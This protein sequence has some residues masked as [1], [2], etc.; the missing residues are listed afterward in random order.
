M[1]YARRFPGFLS[2]DGRFFKDIK[3][4]PKYTVRLSVNGYNLTSNFNPEAFR[5]NTADPA[6]GL[7]FGR[8]GGA[9]RPILMSSS[10]APGSG[11]R[12]DIFQGRVFAREQTGDTIE[13][14]PAFPKGYAGARYQRNEVQVCERY[15]R[16]AWRHPARYCNSS[17]RDVGSISGG[18]DG[19]HGSIGG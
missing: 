1:P 17:I 18:P 2:V 10:G 15:S 3:V 7:F 8:R 14:R 19:R 11:F 16:R 12:R 6:F 5:N 4:N 13:G 9:S